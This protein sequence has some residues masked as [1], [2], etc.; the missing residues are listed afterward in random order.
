[1]PDGMRSETTL[2]GQRHLLRPAGN[3]ASGTV[4]FPETVP[5][6]AK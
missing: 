2:A 3:T 1:M 4:L 5:D 6:P